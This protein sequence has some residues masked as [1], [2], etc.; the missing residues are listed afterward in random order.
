MR[1]TTSGLHDIGKGFSL[2]IFQ[3]NEHFQQQAAVVQDDQATPEEIASAGDCALVCLTKEMKVKDD[4]AHY[5]ICDKAFL[6][7]PLSL[8]RYFLPYPRLRD[9]EDG[10]MIPLKPVFHT[11]QKSFSN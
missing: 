5:N 3:E 10:R 4:A 7:N 11:R 6:A 8:Y 2:E 9:I 1:G